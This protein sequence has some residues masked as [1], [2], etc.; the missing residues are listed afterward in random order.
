MSSKRDQRQRY[1][2]PK[3]KTFGSVRNLTVGSGAQGADDRFVM[4]MMA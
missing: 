4:T 1:E 2:T 3:L